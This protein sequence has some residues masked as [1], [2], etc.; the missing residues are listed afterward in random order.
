MSE[1]EA[2]LFAIIGN[3]IQHSLSPLM[4][5]FLLKKMTLKGCYHAF[6]VEK[7]GLLD[8]LRG[9][10]ALGFRGFNVTLPHKQEIMRHLDEVSEDAQFM[11]AVNTVLLENGKR[12]G[13]NTDNLGFFQALKTRNIKIVDTS[14]VLLGAGGVA[15]AAIFS[16]IQHGAR[17]ISIHNRTIARASRLAKDIKRAS[18]SLEVEVGEM[19]PDAIKKKL[20]SCDL[21]INATSVGLWPEI[22]KTPFLFDGPVHGLVAMDLI[23]NPL[24][25]MFLNS[26]ESAGATVVDGLD[27][28]IFQ[29]LASLK[30]WLNL[31]D[32]LSIYQPELRN[33]LLKKLQCNGTD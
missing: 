22:D 19:T 10:S 23:Y 12:T 33:F 15:R 14:V 27:M 21:L 11:A 24:K 29:G 30:I 26:A 17:R 9:M 8:A 18:Q 25:T 3:P 13:F 16:L 31:E 1:K 5:T 4:H 32:D 28:F 20:P 2:N 7:N 6:R